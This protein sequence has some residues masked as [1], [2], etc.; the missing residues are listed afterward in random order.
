MSLTLLGEESPQFVCLEHPES[1]ILSI[2]IFLV[3]FF[4]LYCYNLLKCSV[5][6]SCF[7]ALLYLSSKKSD[8]VI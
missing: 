3:F 8:L 7:F 5:L 4:K 2:K 1:C 6:C